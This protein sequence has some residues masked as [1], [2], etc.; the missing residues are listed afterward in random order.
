M[1]FLLLMYMLR[2]GKI[3]INDIIFTQKGVVHFE[4]KASKYIIESEN[5]QVTGLTNNFELRF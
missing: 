2:K 1:T 3:T 4:T 5:I